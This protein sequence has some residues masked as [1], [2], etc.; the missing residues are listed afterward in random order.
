MRSKWLLSLGAAALFTATAACAQEA[1]GK[2]HGKVIDPTGVPKTNGTVGLSSDSGKTLKYSLPVDAQ[3]NFTGDNIAPG[4]YTMVYK[5]PEMAADKVADQI[6]GV[7]IVSG[8]DTAQDDDLSRQAYIDKLTPEQ[9]KQVEEVKKKNAEAIKGNAVVMN[10]NADLKQARE[11]NNNKQFDKAEALM[12][13]D[14]AVPIKSDGEII[15]YELAISQMGQKKYD[16]AITSLKKTVELATAN[17]KQNPELLGGAQGQLGEA[18]AMTNKGDDAAA[19]YDA[20]AKVNPTKA[21]AY[22]TNEAIVLQKAN[23]LDGS[24]AAADKAI[25]ANPALPLPYYLKG[26][27]LIPKATTDPKGN[28]VL[29]PGMVDAYQKYL[30]LAPTGPYAQS[31]TEVLQGLKIPVKSSYKAGKKSGL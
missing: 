26:Q 1:P 9:R 11:D 24:A 6:D 27:A 31:V 8:Q 23:N 7:K 13:K 22:Y 29:P 18:Y 28:W 20:A 14:T 4:T 21:G 17:K 5:T 3:G 15:W 19:A 25:A 10:L 12:L 2:I 16:D 30:E